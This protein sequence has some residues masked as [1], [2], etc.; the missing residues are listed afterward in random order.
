[1]DRPLHDH[2]RD[3]LALSLRDLS[4]LLHAS[5]IA[6]VLVA[7]FAFVRLAQ[8]VPDVPLAPFLLAVL[9]TQASIALHNAWAD[10]D[11]DARTKPW[12]AVP[13]GALSARAALA[14]AAVLGAAGAAVAFAVSPLVGAL[15]VLGTA[16]GYAYSAGLHRTPLSWLPFAVALPTLAVASLAV[17]GA[18]DGLPFGVYL[19]GLPLVL[20]VHLADQAPDV[21]RD[22]A[23]GSRGL[24]VRLGLSR[25]LAACWL[26]LGAAAVLASVV[27]PYGILP[28]PLTA[29]ALGLGAVS[30]LAARRSLAA[31][32]ALVM[33]AAVALGADHVR[34]LAGAE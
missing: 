31:H 27:R 18:L 11:H 9:L 7:A 3:R 29:L 8:R 23:A 21:A 12:R 6:F 22:A 24:A 14:W 16:C 25:A 15:V 10:R 30:V 33:A 17:A 13:R 26:A 2:I 28:G 20:A 34:A 32:R 19:I 5:A 4:E 1:M